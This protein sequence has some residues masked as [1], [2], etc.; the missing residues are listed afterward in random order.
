[1]SSVCHQPPHRVYA[2]D[3]AFATYSVFATEFGL[4]TLPALLRESSLHLCSRCRLRDRFCTRDIFHLCNRLRICGRFCLCS[5][6]C[7]CGDCA[8]TICFCICNKIPATDSTP[9]RACTWN[10]LHLCSLCIPTRVCVC[11]MSCLYIPVEVCAAVHHRCARTRWVH[12][13]STYVAQ[14]SHQLYH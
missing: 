3:P 1:M 10:I 8:S 6:S 9:T 12:S 13:R 4:A 5:T 7:P 14:P 2:T 11:T